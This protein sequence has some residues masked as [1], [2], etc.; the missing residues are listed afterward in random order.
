LVAPSCY[1]LNAE[2]EA[3][4]QRLRD[5]L[6]EAVAAVCAGAGVA[7]DRLTFAFFGLP[8]YGEVRADVPAID[9]AVGAA[10]GHDRFRCDNDMVCGW[11]GSLGGADGVNV[12]SGTGSMTYGER[13]G[14]RARVGGW[15]ELIGDEGSGYWIGR[16]GL[17][18]F[19]QM[20]D[21]RGTPGPLLD[22]L[23]DR[24]GLEVDVDLVDVVMNRWRGERARVAAVS[25]LVVEAARLGDGAA[26]A[27][28]SAAG[29]ELA[30]L[31]EATRRRLGYPDDEAVPVSYSGGVFAADEVRD[32]FAQ[33]LAERSPAYRLQPPLFA[34]VVG[35]ALY[36]AKLAGHPLDD[37]ARAR[38]R[39]ASPKASSRRS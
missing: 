27:I 15:G 21:G 24:L 31:V 5:V 26:G 22:L 37:A 11:A 13:G 34:P 25:R 14:A 33:R 28:L 36:A 8:A 2:R 32:A 30:A 3:G 4:L 17:Q 35:A 16:R 18:A 23:R 12:I 29:E 10:L 7:A 1:Y 20:S 19:S 9:A 38:L 6:G 39:S